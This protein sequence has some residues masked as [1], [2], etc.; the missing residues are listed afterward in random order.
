MGGWAGPSVGVMGRFAFG[1]GPASMR[2]PMVRRSLVLTFL[3][4]FCGVP[5]V[6]RAQATKAF[7][8]PRFN[9]GF[10]YDARW[11]PAVQAEGES[12]TFTLSEGEVHVS[13]QRDPNTRH[14]KSREALADEHIQVWKNR[15]DFR[16]LER[17]DTSLGGMPA[18]RVRGS[19]R[20]YDA[21]TPY[22][23]ELYVLERNGKLYVL[24][25]SGLFD[26]S[27]PYWDGYQKMLKSFRF[28]EATPRA[29]TMTTPRATPA[30]DRTAPEPPAP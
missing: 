14:H 1:T 12:V 18:T 19:A 8:H 21:P 25:Y 6:A 11:I 23:L 9:F 29:A 7:E 26:P 17:D 28:K 15:L 5:L 13:V 16:E 10:S 20:L 30:P 22:R 3:V 24:K 4:A 27:L 2:D